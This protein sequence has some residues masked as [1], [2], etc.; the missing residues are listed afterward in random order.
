M[1]NKPL[2]SIA[3]CVYNGEKFLV[4]QLE[5]LVHQTY[6]PL[7]I[8]AVDDRSTDGSYEILK[9]Y[10]K[11]YPFFKVYENDV[12]LG[13]VKN[14]EKALS[15]CSGE[16]IAL[17]DQDDIWDLDKIRLQEENI[18]DNILIYHDSAFIEEDGEDMKKNMS[19]VIH[20]YRG[21]NPEVFLLI[22]SVSGHSCFFRRSLIK[23][24]LP[25][26]PYFFHDH[27]IAYVATNLGKID[28]IPKSLVYY[29]QH[30]ASSTDILLKRT[31]QDI[32]YHE[33]RDVA[34]LKKELGWLKQCQSFVKNKD[35]AFIDEFVRLF[36]KRLKT[37]FSI[38]YAM[39]LRKHY[40]NLYHNKKYHRS[41]KSGF[42]YRQAWGLKG[43]LWWASIFA[44]KSSE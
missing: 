7:E 35:Q 11:E 26:N 18:K 43:K 14:F 24:F 28:F 9:K 21:D 27:W 30:P 6:S 39:L 19:D 40:D 2:V 5:S 3:L 12:N 20:L 34:R 44:K 16:Y 38:D 23:E 22:N 37:V 8:I 36:E 32:Y 31:K 4:E 25:L 17:C 13:F 42:I 29:R 33:N 1:S 15:L 10:S 41:G